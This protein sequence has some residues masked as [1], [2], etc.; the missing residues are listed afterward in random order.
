[1]KSNPWIVSG[2][3]L[4][5]AVGASGIGAFYYYQYNITENA[6]QNLVGEETIIA[7]IGINYGNG[8]IHWQNSTTIPFNSTALYFLNTTNTVNGTQYPFGFYVESINNVMINASGNEK[9]WVYSVNNNPVFVGAD[10]YNLKFGDVLV[11]EYKG[12]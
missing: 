2:L 9:Y 10:A 12:F 11:W 3:I 6:Y 7:S 5:W 4:I 8:T 1:M